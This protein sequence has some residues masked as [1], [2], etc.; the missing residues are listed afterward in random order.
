[1]R[2]WVLLITLIWTPVD[3]I[4]R[5]L[6][7]GMLLGGVNVV[8]VVGARARNIRDNLRI[9]KLCLCKQKGGVRGE[10]RHYMVTLKEVHSKEILKCGLTS[11]VL[12]HAVGVT[13][14]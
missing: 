14:G 12:A 3:F 11:H 6:H 5:P 2:A 7:R 13:I 4:Y 10:N 1:M 8:G 9:N